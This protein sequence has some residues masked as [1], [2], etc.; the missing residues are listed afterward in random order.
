MKRAQG[1]AIFTD[2]KISVNTVSETRRA[3]IVNWLVVHRGILITND[4]TDARIE[5]FWK[6]WGSEARIIKVEIEEKQ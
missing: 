1:Y 4:M 5:S 3:S 2:D 6:R